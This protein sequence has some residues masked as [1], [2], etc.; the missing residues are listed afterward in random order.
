[1]SNH[2]FYDLG[3]VCGRF[4]HEHL[5][6]VSLFDTS[7]SLCKRTLILVGSAQEFG[8]LRNPFR[9]ETRIDVI[10][11]TY[12]GESEEV[13]T[14]RGI[15]D[16]TNEYDISSAWGKFVKSEVEYHKH[17][18]ANLMVYGNDEFRSKWFDPNDLIGTAELII[19]RSTIPISATMVRGFLLINNETSW[20]KATH[21]LIHGMYNR[22][23][24]ELMNV[25][26]YKEIYDRVRVGDLTLD[27][28]MKVYKEFEQEDK[29]LKLAELKNSL[30][31]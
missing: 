2:K 29:E 10:R 18:F 17:K 12:P 28:F 30:S 14:V 21:P 13:L 6:H 23:R 7:M 25:P 3:V 24:D 1:M 11:E 19:P 22:L 4:G 26:V 31:K 8:T 27:N 9:L 5:G 16:L 20:Q 15:T